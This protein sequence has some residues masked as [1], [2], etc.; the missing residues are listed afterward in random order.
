MQSGSWDPDSGNSLDVYVYSQNGRRI[1]TNLVNSNPVQ[2]FDFIYKADYGDLVI[3]AKTGK[4][5]TFTYTVT[6]QFSS[7]KTASTVTSSCLP[8][9]KMNAGEINKQ[10]NVTS[11]TNSLGYKRGHLLKPVYRREMKSVNSAEKEK[12]IQL[13][14]CFPEMPSYNLTVSTVSP[15]NITIATIGLYNLTVT[16]AGG[17]TSPTVSTVGPY[18][19]IVSTADPSNAKDSN[20]GSLSM[21]ALKESGLLILGIGYLMI[22]Q[23]VQQILF[24]FV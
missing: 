5:T 7:N 14:Y 21:F 16:A 17:H 20:S 1:E 9:S 23:V 8:R 19:R 15:Y 4:H 6:V 12:R 18:N 13:H 3:V 24:P 22:Y 10:K 11:F 2:D